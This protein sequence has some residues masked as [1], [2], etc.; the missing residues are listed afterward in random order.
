[1]SRPTATAPAMIARVRFFSARSCSRR[2]CSTTARRSLFGL[3]T[4]RPSSTGAATDGGSLRTDRP[5]PQRGVGSPR[6]TTPAEAEGE[7][8]GTLLERPDPPLVAAGGGGEGHLHRV[9]G[10]R[11]ADRD[12]GHHL[13]QGGHELVERDR[14]PEAALVLAQQRVQDG[15]AAAE[16]EHVLVL[17]TD[18]CSG[19][20]AVLPAR[21]DHL[22]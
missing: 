3:A 4:T 14:A 19:A 20:G 8:A 15:L 17:R 21:Q 1:M 12:G 22:V 13:P 10:G 9:A 16:P 5:E 2:I 6:C 11:D 7:H 18:E